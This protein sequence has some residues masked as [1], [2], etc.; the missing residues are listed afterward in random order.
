MPAADPI[1]K[2]RTEP[3]TVLVGVVADGGQEAKDPR[4]S[5]AFS[6]LEAAA[7][8]TAAAAMTAAS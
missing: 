4:L 3:L 7:A 1:G 5:H 2:P 8:T 6:S